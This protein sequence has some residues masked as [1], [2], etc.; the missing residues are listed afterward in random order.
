MTFNRLDAPSSSSLIKILKRKV[1]KQHILFEEDPEKYTSAESY[2]ISW[3]N[4]S[5]LSKTEVYEITRNSILHPECQDWIDK[6]SHQNTRAY[7]DQQSRTIVTYN[8]LAIHIQSYKSKSKVTVTL[9]LINLSVQQTVPLVNVFID[10]S[11][12]INIIA[13]NSMGEIHYYRDCFKDSCRTLKIPLKYHNEYITS[14]KLVHADQAVIGSSTGEI[15]FVNFS[16]QG[17][18]DLIQLGTFYK[19]SFNATDLLSFSNFL[20]L[21]SLHC[22]SNENKPTYAET[23]PITNICATDNL[24]YICSHKDISIWQLKEPGEVEL[25]LRKEIELEIIANVAK[26]IPSRISKDEIRCEIVNMNIVARDE[27]MILVSYTVPE[28]KEYVQYVVIKFSLEF[29]EHQQL[30]MITKH[31]ASIPYSDIRSSLQKQPQ[32]LSTEDIGFIAF[33]KAVIAISLTRNSAFEESVVLSRPE[34]SV[35]WIERNDNTMEDI[36]S[37]LIMTS[38][39]GVL[40]LKI[41]KVKLK[42]PRTTGN[43]YASLVENIEERDTMVFKSRLEQALFFGS[44][45]EKSPLQFPLRVEQEDISMAVISLTSEIQNGNC[46]FLPKDLDF[47]LFINARYYFQKRIFGIL[48]DNKLHNQIIAKDRYELLKSTE[49]YYISALLKEYFHLY[50][51]DAHFKQS[52]I[53]IIQ[54]TIGSQEKDYNLLKNDFL[55]SYTMKVKVFLRR[56]ALSKIFPAAIDILTWCVTKTYVFEERCFY[57]YALDKRNVKRISAQLGSILSIV[58][59]NIVEDLEKYQKPVDP[60]KVDSINQDQRLDIKTNEFPSIPVI[61]QKILEIAKMLL[62]TLKVELDVDE[63]PEVTQM[64]N[65]LRESVFEGLCAT[66]Q[67][68]LAINLAKKHNCVSFVIGLIQRSHL[69]HDEMKKMNINYIELFGKYYFNQL[70][71]YLEK[72]DQYQDMLDLC[73]LFPDF[74]NEFLKDNSVPKVSWIFYLRQNDFIRSLNCLHTYLETDLTEEQRSFLLSW[75]KMISIAVSETLETNGET[76]IV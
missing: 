47:D 26:H 54:A 10:K 7:F 55:K 20:K 42:E 45:D 19:S 65:N 37:V 3:T 63:N 71:E 41:N 1:N 24:Y 22:L 17:N 29:D 61:K 68:E 34:D 11:N 50:D 13:A 76:S 67:F 56:L 48:K 21:R 64:Y 59:K 8:E 33:D 25:I 38:R 72:Q 70:L 49:L 43:I 74:A 14:V 62:N 18:E 31:T 40:K 30:S 2:P 35:L 12:M 16:L 52:L 39:S 32:L 73:L 75:Y 4:P 60:I 58:F 6:S 66:G 15:Y 5:I 9:P 44:P 23:S 53:E 27:I 51:S 57:I 46:A 28:M 36:N 69:S